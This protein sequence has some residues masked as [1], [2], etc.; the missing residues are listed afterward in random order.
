M[1]DERLLDTLSKSCYASKS[2]RFLSGGKAGVSIKRGHCGG[3]LSAG[4][5]H[6]TF[7]DQMYIGSVDLLS[8]CASWT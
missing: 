8:Q 3:G 7:C 2:Y 4:V 5:L 1:E 6:I